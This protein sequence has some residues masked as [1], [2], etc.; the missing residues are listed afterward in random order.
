MG[1]EAEKFHPRYR[2]PKIKEKYA[3]NG[4]LLLFVGR[5]AEVK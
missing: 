3:P 5:L 2:E 4:P 1:V